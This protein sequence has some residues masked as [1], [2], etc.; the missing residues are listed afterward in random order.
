MQLI[1]NPFAY[2]TYKDLENAYKESGDEVNSE[3]F[4]FVLNE[5]FDNNSNINRE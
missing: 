2:K 5:K 1:N 4:N 3:V